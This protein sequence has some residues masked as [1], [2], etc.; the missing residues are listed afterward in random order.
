MPPNNVSVTEG[1]TTLPSNDTAMAEWSRM[2][3][4][5]NNEQVSGCVLE[6][7]TTLSQLEGDH[8]ASKGANQKKSVNKR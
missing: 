4:P 5:K 6:D 7:K 3:I 8:L 1:A 2:D